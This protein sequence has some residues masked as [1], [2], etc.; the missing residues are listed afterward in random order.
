MVKTIITVPHVCLRK[1][2]DPGCDKN[3]YAYGKMFKKYLPNSIL[4]TSDTPRYGCDLNRKECRNVFMRA[5]LTPVIESWK[6][7]A[8][9]LDIHSFPRYSNFAPP[10]VKLVV[11]HASTASTREAAA[12]LYEILHGN[13]FQVS[14]RGSVFNDIIRHAGENQIPAA[15]LEIRDDVKAAELF[16]E[17][18][19]CVKFWVESLMKI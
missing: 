10:K 17:V 9:L 4:K 14:L 1:H 7:N 6:G 11:L 16:P 8:V 13:G 19:S 12:L 2:D 3:A 5:K 15:L 18:V